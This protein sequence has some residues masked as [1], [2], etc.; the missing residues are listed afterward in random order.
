MKYNSIP[1]RSQSSSKSQLFD[2]KDH[3]AERAFDIWLSRG[4]KA[5]YA[6]AEKDKVPDALLD[7]IHNDENTKKILSKKV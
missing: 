1:S 5:L 2:H 4:L 6:G 3:G 7:I